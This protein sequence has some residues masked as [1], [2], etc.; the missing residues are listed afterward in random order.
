MRSRNGSCSSS[1]STYSIIFL[2]FYSSVIFADEYLISYRYFVKNSAL[3]N[4]TL[5]VSKAM[6]KC[7]GKPYDS[8]SIEIKDTHNLKQILL[9][10]KEKFTYFLNKIGFYITNEELTYNG[11]HVARTIITL[12]T[13]CF[14][15][16]FNDN[17][18]TISPLK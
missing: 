17:F 14:K 13:T 9:Q 11:N 4:E 3:Y 12:K 7:S 10:N 5:D 2:L 6:K 1:F 15:V 16:D 8:L 18:V